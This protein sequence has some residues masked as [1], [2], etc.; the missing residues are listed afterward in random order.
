MSPNDRA[1]EVQAKVLEYLRAG[2]SIVWVVDPQTLT[3]T[4][5]HRDGNAQVL[6]QAD[7]LVAPGVLE[8]LCVTVRKLFPK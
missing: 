8:N 3:V 5:Y 1:S 2:V 4:V 7:E 6:Q